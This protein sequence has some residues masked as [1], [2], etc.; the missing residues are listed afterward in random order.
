MKP[1]FFLIHK[2]GGGGGSVKVKYIAKQVFSNEILLS[3]NY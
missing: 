3:S 2:G 1:A